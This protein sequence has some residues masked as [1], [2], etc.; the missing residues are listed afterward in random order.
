MTFFS[1]CHTTVFLEPPY[2]GNLLNP[3]PGILYEKE[4]RYA[5][6]LKG[7]PIRPLK[8]IR[9]TSLEIISLQTM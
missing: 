9:N 2:Q 4:T 3:L 6:T 5:N 1:E 7:L 8:N